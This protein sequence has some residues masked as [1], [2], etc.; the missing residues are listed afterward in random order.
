MD[1]MAGRAACPIRDLQVDDRGRSL[2]ASL[3]LTTGPITVPAVYPFMCPCAA[4]PQCVPGYVRTAPGRFG[5]RRQPAVAPATRTA[6]AA[7]RQAPRGL[8]TLPSP[9]RLPSDAPS[10]PCGRYDARP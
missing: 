10:G 4:T 2:P 6:V 9:R 7:R 3:M 1:D 8:R 5:P